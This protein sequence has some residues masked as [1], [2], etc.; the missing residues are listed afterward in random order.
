[1]VAAINAKLNASEHAVTLGCFTHFHTV[2][3]FRE[4]PF[5]VGDYTTTVVELLPKRLLEVVETTLHWEE[6]ESPILK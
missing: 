2:T 1:M 3:E 4:I 6:A 5:M